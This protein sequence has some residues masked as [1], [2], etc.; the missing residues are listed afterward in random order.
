M[1]RRCDTRAALHFLLALRCSPASNCC[2]CCI[3]ALR[4][5]IMTGRPYSSMVPSHGKPTAHHR[6]A[7]SVADEG[8]DAAHCKQAPV[9]VVGVAGCNTG[10]LNRCSNA[11]RC[12]GEMQDAASGAAPHTAIRIVARKVAACA[13]A[14]VAVGRLTVETK[15]SLLKRATMHTNPPCICDAV[16]TVLVYTPPASSLTSQHLMPR[17]SFSP[18]RGAT[19]AAASST[20]TRATPSQSP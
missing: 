8:A 18:L 17:A 6:S 19:E 9:C 2:N 7:H 11:H 5:C 13:P 15:T 10:W 14:V 4:P 3:Y 12:V 20:T 16:F 1:R